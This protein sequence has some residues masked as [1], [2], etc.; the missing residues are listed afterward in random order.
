MRWLPDPL[1]EKTIEL[2]ENLV[3]PLIVGV[4]VGLAVVAL[5]KLYEMVRLLSSMLTSINP[6]LLVGSTIIALLFGYLIIKFLAETK[7]W[8]C[9]TELMIEAYH[10]RSGFLSW[11]DTISKTLASAVTI[12]FGGSAGLEGPSLLLGGGLTSA[13]TQ[14]FGLK[15]DAIKKLYL[16][17]AAAGFAAIFKAPLTGILLA[18]E[19]PYRRDLETGVFVPAAIASVT[20]YL[21]SFAMLGGEVLFPILGLR[22]AIPSPIYILHS[23]VLGVL[24]ALVALLF[25]TSMD[26]LGKLSDFAAYRSPI[27]CMAILGGAALGIIGLFFPQVIG[28]GYETIREAATGQLCRLTFSALVGLLLL[29]I[30]ATSLTIR[31]GGSGGL[32]I[33]SLYIGGILGIIYAKTFNLEPIPIYVMIAMAATIAAANKTLMTSVAFVAET[34]GSSSVI[35]S[36]ISA[37]ISYFISGNRSLYSNQLVSKPVEEEEALAEL[38]HLIKTRKIRGLDKRKAEEFMTSKPIGL[39]EDIPLKE[40]LTYIKAYGFRVYPVVNREQKLLGVIKVEDVLSI[41]PD[42][43]DLPVSSVLIRRPLIAL[44]NHSILRVMEKMFEAG[45]DH[46]YVVDSLK[47][48][49]LVGVIAAIDI[50]RKMADILREETRKPKGAS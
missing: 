2:L 40:A 47:N 30:F 7:S 15:P 12:G 9:G 20:S 19:I 3:M 10:Y 42:K 4:V 41:P 8:G 33:P 45:E 6:L 13:I 38:R 32:F 24:S 1:S 37:S 35:L 50:L 18:L 21:V 17:G 34:I 23:T 39:M 22:L 31:L 46:V 27:T 48:R 29:K 25:I 26:K 28:L 43:W 11:K 36:V 5:Y 49:R 16:C 44:R 14:K